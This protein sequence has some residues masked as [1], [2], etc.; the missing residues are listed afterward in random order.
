LQFYKQEDMNDKTIIEIIVDRITNSPQKRITFA[1]YMNLALYHPQHGYYSAGVVGIG[2]EGDFFTSSSLGADLGELLSEQF[3][4]MWRNLGL[5]ERFILLEMGAGLGFLADDILNYL[6][7]K[8]PDFF[9]C[10]EYIIIETSPT[11]R[12]RQQT[13]INKQFYD[14]V[15]WQSW[16][17]IADNSIIGCCFS[18]ELIDA[19]PVHQIAIENNSI[20]EVYITYDAGEFKEIY[21]EPSTEAIEEYF[22]FIDIDFSQNKYPDNYRTEVNLAALSWLETVSKKIDRGYLLTIDYG[23]TAEKY[24]HPQRSRGTLKCYYQHHHHDNPYINI[25]RQD[26]TT[27]VD[28]TALEKRGNLFDLNTIGKTKQGM[29]LMALGLG[30][31]LDMLSRGG[32]SFQEIMQRRDALHQLIDPMGLGGFEVL[33]QGKNLNELARKLKGLSI[34][35]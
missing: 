34:P 1:D 6:H 33:I 18:N 35:K 2:K 32:Y 17:K 22:T 21:D 30:D 14:R 5:P 11:L 4:E 8:Y 28:F 24:Y 25:G 13:K 12:D 26:I 16:E 15:F 29:F 20:K 19:F 10:L 7:Q 3:V 27:H 23:Y 9:A 31:R